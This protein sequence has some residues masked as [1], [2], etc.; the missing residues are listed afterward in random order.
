MTLRQGD[1]VLVPFPF[2]D[3]IQS[4]VRPAIVISSELVNQTQDVILA[5]ISSSIRNDEFSFGLELGMLDVPLH[6]DSQVLFHKIFV[7]EK[8]LVVKVISRLQE[9]YRKALIDNIKRLFDQ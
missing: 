2:S 8:R 7:V 5:Q 3:G 1:I 9:H 6:K 4:K